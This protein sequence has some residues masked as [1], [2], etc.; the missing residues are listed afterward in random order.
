M[1]QN[2]PDF[3]EQ[4]F[5]Q[6]EKLQCLGQ[7][8][9]SYNLGQHESMPMHNTTQFRSDLSSLTYGF[10]GLGLMG[11]SL[12]KAI[13][14]YVIC[15]ESNTID[16]TGNLDLA[17]CSKITG[18][19]NSNG[20]IFAMDISKNSLED[21]CLDGTIDKGFS[22]CEIE[23]MLKVCDVVF[24]CLYPKAT[25][26][27]LTKY[28]NCFKSGAVVTDIAGVKHQLLSQLVWTRSDVVFVPGHPMAGS[29]R[30][31]FTHASSEIFKG[32]NY[33]F[34]EP[35]VANC[36]SVT[37][38][39]NNTTDNTT[40]NATDNATDN[41]TRA[42]NTIKQLATVIGFTRIIETTPENHDHKIA[43]T[44][45]LCHVIASSLVDS[46]EDTDI[47]A[48]GGGSYEDLTRIAMIN[49]P[50]W[51][52]LFLANKEQLLDH[53]KSFQSS[54]VNLTNAIETDNSEDLMA[55][56]ENVR[57]RRISMARPKVQ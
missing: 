29:E 32:R 4:N 44:S 47:T 49:A 57:Q 12:A 38:D 28:Q 30:E 26:E 3:G 22:E 25:L 50:L 43:F 10:I 14:K 1:S 6:Q 16:F 37:T 18:N 23:H 35:V 8:E 33:I 15:D 7:Q 19:L 17:D 9:K 2:A 39:S 52:E 42:L 24:I 55:Y 13:R 34:M 41:A 21:A 48:F 27:F 54:L 45:Q 20:K 5:E 40:N 51:T 36:V 56:L 53:I 11:G 31:G 46:A